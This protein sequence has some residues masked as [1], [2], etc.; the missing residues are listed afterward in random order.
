MAS[1]ATR[2]VIRRRQSWAEKARWIMKS[3]GEPTSPV[4]L[5]YVVIV[6]ASMVERVLE[7]AIRF[8]L[9]RLTKAQWETL[10]SENA[11]L[12]TLSAKINLGHAMRVYGNKTRADLHHVREIRNIFAH[13]ERPVT[14]TT[15]RIRDLCRALSTPEGWPPD[16]PEWSR[17]PFSLFKFT[18]DMLFIEIRR[19]SN[20]R[21]VKRQRLKR[22]K[23]S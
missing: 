15:K 7:D 22:P 2:K 13:A 19:L 21:L 14:F 8:R 11:P 18:I 4:D 6:G 23:L 17:S 3:V 12:G 9:V 20:P 10:F 1:K 16:D 5:R